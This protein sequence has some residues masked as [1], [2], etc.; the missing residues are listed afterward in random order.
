M[1]TKP[2]EVS[3]RSYLLRRMA[4]VSGSYIYMRMMGAMMER[5]AA[6]AN[7]EEVRKS[8]DVQLEANPEERARL[9][10]SLTFM[11][12]LSLADMQ[13]AHRE[14]LLVAS[15]AE[16]SIPVMAAD[17][18]WADPTLEED[19]RAVH[20]LVVESLVFSLAPF[21]VQSGSTT[22]DGKPAATNL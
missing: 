11:Q 14:A 10:I 13:F 15:E 20:D 17:G 5:V 1:K 12:G 2:V 18:R 21:F 19:P 7:V 16:H 22:A 6:A 9:L 4:P 8:A 3:G